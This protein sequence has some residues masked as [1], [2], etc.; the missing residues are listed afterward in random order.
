MD[1]PA[2]ERHP[3]GRPTKLGVV[4][5]MIHPAFRLLAV[6]A[7]C[8]CANPTAPTP[9]LELAT[10]DYQ[11]TFDSF[12]GPR[13][14]ITVRNVST[15]AVMLSGCLGHVY[16]IPEAKVGDHWRTVPQTSCESWAPVEL[17]PGGLIALQS[18]VPAIGE[19]RFR[20]PVFES[21]STQRLD[22]AVSNEF[23]VR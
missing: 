3:L 5:D 9:T 14:G 16:P 20:M 2:A 10:D 12:G 7:C 18:T 8:S 4:V 17:A 13:I 11:Y 19:F 22:P 21:S 15:A 1:P 6:L 23:L